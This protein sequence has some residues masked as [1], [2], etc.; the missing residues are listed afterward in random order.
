LFG[1][2]LRSGFD[3]V[4]GVRVVD[5]FPLGVRCL[6][7]FSLR[8]LDGVGVRE[9]YLAVETGDVAY[10]VVRT[11]AFKSHSVVEMETWTVRDA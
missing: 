3:E 5:G 6:L 11:N 10:R 7:L 1:A 9:R 4:V 8:A 2:G